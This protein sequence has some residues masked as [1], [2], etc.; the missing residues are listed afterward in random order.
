MIVCFSKNDKFLNRY[1]ECLH[2]KS[3]KALDVLENFTL[4]LDLEAI[5]DKE[6]IFLSI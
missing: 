6:N 1:K 4:L 3:E 5:K 2:V